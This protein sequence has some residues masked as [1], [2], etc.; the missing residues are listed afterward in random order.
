VGLS[1]VHFCQ[2]CDT[3]ATCRID[4]CIYPHDVSKVHEC[5]ERAYYRRRMAKA[6]SSECSVCKRTNCN[7]VHSGQTGSMEQATF[8][9]IGP[10]VK[11][12]ICLVDCEEYLE[13]GICEHSL[14]RLKPKSDNPILMDGDFHSENCICKL[15]RIQWASQR[16]QVS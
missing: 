16:I 6:L 7:R 8:P 4:R 15:C 13:Q 2:F 1:H 9:T 10:R 14:A 3:T 12:P 11:L 5:D